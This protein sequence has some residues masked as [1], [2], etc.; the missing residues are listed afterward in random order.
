MKNFISNNW[1]KILVLI[2]GFFIIKN[3]LFKIF[4]E[5][6]LID[7]YIK[8]GKEYGTSTSVIPS[9][10]IDSSNFTFGD[11]PF[12]SDIVKLAIILIVSISLITILTNLAEKAGAKK[13]KKK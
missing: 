12:D 9:T 5:K 13:E 7:D 11:M 3:A 4:S 2:G 1:K 6:V 8:Y 10:S